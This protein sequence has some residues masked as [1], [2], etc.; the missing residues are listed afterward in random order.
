MGEFLFS[1]FREKKNRKKSPK[2]YS[3]NV[4]EPLEIYTTP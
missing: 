2:Y 3:L 1:N 4:R